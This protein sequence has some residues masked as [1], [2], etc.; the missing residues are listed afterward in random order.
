[1]PEWNISNQ[2]L[3]KFDAMLNIIELMFVYKV[4]LFFFDFI[5]LLYN[6]VQKGLS[7]VVY[8]HCYLWFSSVI[9]WAGKFP[10]Q[11][12]NTGANFFFSP[13]M[14]LQSKMIFPLSFNLS[15]FSSTQTDKILQECKRESFDLLW[16]FPMNYDQR[17]TLRAI[18]Y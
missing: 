17:Q 9:A 10:T 12:A 18:R 14:L 4:Q 1:M 8:L 13:Y 3:G 11:S 15:I 6:Y 5:S 2:Y 16:K 7:D